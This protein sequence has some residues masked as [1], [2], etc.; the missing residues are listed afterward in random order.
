MITE[1]SHVEKYRIKVS[2]RFALGC[3]A[4]LVAN[5]MWGMW[6]LGTMWPPVP[7]NEFWYISLGFCNVV[8]IAG[9]HIAG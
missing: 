8:K 4:D 7:T 5:G 3:L 2:K 9:L 6:M 1:L